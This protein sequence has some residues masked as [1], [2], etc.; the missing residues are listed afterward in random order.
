MSSS[1]KP[2]RKSERLIATI[3]A[4]EDDGAPVYL[5]AVGETDLRPIL[6]Q[7]RAV[8]RLIVGAR[9]TLPPTDPRPVKLPDSEERPA[10]ASSPD[11]R[12]AFDNNEIDGIDA[13][14]HTLDLALRGCWEEGGSND[15]DA[16]RVTVV[17]IR[18]D[19]ERHTARLYAWAKEQ[20]EHG[21]G[22]D[23]REDVA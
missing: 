22:A 19:F 20:R 6:R 10:T 7:A 13:A 3:C 12:G 11:W 1:S 17:G 16:L 14:L 5:G 8:R 23:D 9:W 4:T 18:R 21:D 2:S 15:I